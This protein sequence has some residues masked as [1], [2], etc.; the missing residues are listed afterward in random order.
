MVGGFG[1]SGFN[2]A[3]AWV[4]IATDCLVAVA[5]QA[6]AINHASKNMD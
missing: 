4:A 6:S 3:L 1:K 5:A 2:V